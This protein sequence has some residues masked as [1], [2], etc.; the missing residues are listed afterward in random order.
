MATGDSLHTFVP[1]GHEPPATNYATLDLRN[2][3]PVLDFDA[4]TSE[5]VYWTD[6][7]SREYG[8]GGITLTVIWAA[9]TAVTGNVVWEAAFERLEDEGTDIDAD[10]FAA[11]QAVT[12]TA[13]ATSG[14]LQ[15]GAITFTNG[16]QI[17]S[18]AVGEAFR[19][20]LRRAP[21]DAGDTMAGDAEAVAVELRET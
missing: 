8:G 19:L 4:T 11:V 16:A 15:Y 9:T 5:T 3:H 14:A 12:S 1:G 6:V 13:P 18:L 17:D 10:S 20:L 7:L 21:A 2:A